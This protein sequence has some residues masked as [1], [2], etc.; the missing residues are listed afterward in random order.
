MDG[1]FFNGFGGGRPASGDDVPRFAGPS[2]FFRLPVVNQ[3]T[4]L[5][6][7]LIGVPSDVGAATRPG[8]RYGPRGVR[9]MSTLIRAVHPITLTSPFDICRIGDMGDVPVNPVDVNDTLRR[10]RAFFEAVHRQGVVPVA[11]GGDHLTTLPILRALCQNRPVALV[12]FDAHSDTDGDYFNGPFEHHG[13]PF[14]RAVEEA[15]ID[16]RRTLQVGLRGTLYHADELDFAR[17][18]GMRLVR[19]EEVHRL[20]ID[21]TIEL[22]RDVVGDAPVYITFDVDCVDPAFA[23]GVGTP[24]VGGLTPIEAQCLVRGLQGLDVI[25]ADVVEVAP[26]LDPS[27]I[28]ALVAAT[29]LFEIL[30]PTADAVALRTSA[31]SRGV[32]EADLTVDDPE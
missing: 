31:P 30:C 22:I 11:V 13:T 26:P 14:R 15:L 9:E 23:P 4:D 20:G 2:T 6:I 5:D 27:G 7:A 25:G 12:Q 21:A 19:I 1:A 10:I 24:E 17:N 29:M 28:T 32:M 8:A 16:P 18:A 3:A